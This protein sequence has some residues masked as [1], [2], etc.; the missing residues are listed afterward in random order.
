MKLL[1]QSIGHLGVFLV[2]VLLFCFCFL[3]FG[4]FFWCQ[5]WDT[6]LDILIEAGRL[7]SKRFYHHSVH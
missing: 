7:H 5:K 4:G 6:V 2:V 3:V 1:G